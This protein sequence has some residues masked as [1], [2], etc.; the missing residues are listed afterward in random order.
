MSGQPTRNEIYFRIWYSY[1]LEVMTETFNRRLD[2]SIHALLLTLG[3][4][5]SVTH[6]PGWVFGIIIAAL[7][8]CQVA[9]QY[10]KQ[11][12]A[13]RQQARRYVKLIGQMHSLSPQEILDHL[14]VIEEF[15][16]TAQSSLFNS[17][18][19]RTFISLN[20]RHREKLTL[21]EKFISSIA[22]GIPR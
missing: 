1:W 19:N 18:R 8:A 13:A 6:Q 14:D 16:S 10:G 5:V 4:L 22:G 17:A 15:D 9:W 7:S 11:G 2:N 21:W 20:M 3:A 12:E